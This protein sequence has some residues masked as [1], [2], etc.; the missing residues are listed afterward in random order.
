MKTYTGCVI[1]PQ[2]LVSSSSN[3]IG[4]KDLKTANAPKASSRHMN[5]FQRAT[6]THMYGFPKADGNCMKQPV[7]QSST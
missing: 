6:S 1:A 4:L 5:G 3:P 7:K 2:A